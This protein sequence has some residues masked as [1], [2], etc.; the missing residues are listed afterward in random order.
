MVIPE[1]LWG[2]AARM[3]VDGWLQP[4]SDALYKLESKRANMEGWFSSKDADKNCAPEFRVSTAYLL[5]EVLYIEESRRGQRESKRLADVM[6]TLGWR[7]A[8]N[9]IKVGKRT[10]RAYT[11]PQPEDRTMRFHWSRWS[12]WIPVTAHTNLLGI[13]LVLLL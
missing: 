2:A 9:S 5:G 12:R 8:Q 7:L 13:G 6:R 1:G 4:I 3:E 10:C 11:K